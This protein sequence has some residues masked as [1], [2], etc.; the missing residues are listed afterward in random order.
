MHKVDNHRAVH[1]G[2]HGAGEVREYL[3]SDIVDRVREG[4]AAPAVCDR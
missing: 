1:G 2:S 3:D 4:T